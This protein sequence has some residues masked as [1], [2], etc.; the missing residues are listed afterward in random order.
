MNPQSERSDLARQVVAVMLSRDAMARSLGITNEQL[1][2]QLVRD[3]G[4]PEGSYHD[5]ISKRQ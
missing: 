1:A 2:M 3:E 4:L 5:V